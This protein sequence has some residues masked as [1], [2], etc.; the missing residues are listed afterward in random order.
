MYLTYILR[1]RWSPK[2]LGVQGVYIDFATTVHPLPTL[3]R[4]LALY[5]NPPPP[6]YIQRRATGMPEH[7]HRA[8]PLALDGIAW[9]FPLLAVL[10]S[11][12][13]GVWVRRP[14]LC[15]IPRLMLHMPTEPTTLYR[16]FHLRAARQLDCLAHLLHRQEAPCQR[17]PQ[18][19]TYVSSPSTAH[20]AADCCCLSSLGAPPVL[21]VPRLD[22]RAHFPHRVQGIR[23]QR[24]HAQGRLLHEVVCLPRTAL[25]RGHLGCI[26]VLESRR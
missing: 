22:D 8:A 2:P 14:R 23:C 16:R 10:N 17:E 13:V 4:A 11:I 19:Q 12:Y 26:R 7:A 3:R 21:A 24:A 5:T 6:N 20:A 18:R 9:H 25:L 1:Q 15:G